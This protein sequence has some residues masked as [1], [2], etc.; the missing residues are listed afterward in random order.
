MA[1]VPVVGTLDENLFFT[2]DLDASAEP[3]RPATVD[4]SLALTFD[5]E[6]TGGTHVVATA[7]ENLSLSM[8]LD[9]IAVMGVAGDVDTSFGGFDME[10]MAVPAVVGEADT[11]FGGFELTA[12]VSG[13]AIVTTDSGFALTLD[14]DATGQTPVVA[15]GDASMPG[16]SMSSGGNANRVVGSVL[17]RLGVFSVTSV[18]SAEAYG[19]V[20]TRFGPLAGIGFASVG[21]EVEFDTLQYTEE[22]F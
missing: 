5:A 6:A 12:T 18:I 13:A 14:V 11:D 22:V 20:D 16:F 10:A 15:W 9:S 7:D 3:D 21:G 1:S 8:G 17:S 19:D 4:A 2:L